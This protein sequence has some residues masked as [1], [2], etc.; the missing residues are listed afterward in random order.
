MC[1]GAQPE[2]M[3]W[4]MLGLSVFLG[5]PQGIVCAVGLNIPHL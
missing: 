3:V 2:R 1:P 4:F 5:K